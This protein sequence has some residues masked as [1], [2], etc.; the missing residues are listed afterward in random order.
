MA[1]FNGLPL[2]HRSTYLVPDSQKLPQVLVAQLGARMHY[3]VPLSL[4]RAGML[5]HFCT[6]MYVGP[7]SSWH[8]LSRIAPLFPE[9]WQ[10]RGFHQLL[11]RQEKGLPGEKVTGFNLFGLR[12]VLALRCRRS[13]EERSRL[14]LEFGR[15]FCELVIKAGV[16]Q[17]DAVYV[18]HTAA[19]PLMAKAREVGMGSIFEQFCA[20]VEVEFQ[21]LHQEKELWPGWESAALRVRI[22]PYKKLQQK[23][24]A[25]A[26]AIICPSSFVAEGL[27]QMGVLSEKIHLIPY[28]VDV[29]GFAVEREPWDGR[30][31][32]RVL[33]VGGISL[34]KGP[35]YLYQALAKANSSQITAR[36]VGPIFIAAPY[37]DLLKKYAELAG[38]V[39][40]SEVRR[41]YQWADL[42]VFPSLCEGSATVT[43][44]ALAAGLPV[45]TTPNAGSVV[46]DGVEAFVVPIRDPAAI[47]DRLERLAVNPALLA[48][49][50]R[51]ARERAADFSWEKYGE[52]LTA[53]LQE[54]CLRGKD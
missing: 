8:L 23:E 2:S 28:G 48:E 7:G 38:I 34:G 54:I 42:F 10:P 47:A 16:P 5:A 25:A 50:A 33:F 27:A 22:P 32:L 11:G 43:Y 52:R 17:A 20:P 24:W 44:E 14:H 6:D 39:P 53:C 29:S 30:R 51:Q 40:R 9:T 31:P 4:H 15:R 13:S 35:Q 18:F 49:M 37:R 12:F 19:L 36:L 3:A 1:C 21:L 46:R 45:I 26:D 41:H